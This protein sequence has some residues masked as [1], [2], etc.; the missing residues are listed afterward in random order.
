MGLHFAADRPALVLLRASDCGPVPQKS[1]HQPPSNQLRADRDVQLVELTYRGGVSMVV[2]LPDAA[3]GLNAVE[4]RLAGSYQGWMKALDHKP[5]DLELPRWKVTSRLPTTAALTAMGMQTAFTTRANFQGMSDERL[6]IQRVLQQ[7]F[8]E[9][10]EEG[11]EA[12]AVTAVV[13]GSLSDVLL[14]ASRSRFM[15][16]T[17]SCTSCATRTRV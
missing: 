10:D 16:T 4:A 6:F 1:P 13:M 5:V 12:A 15:P 11:T 14:H 2:V 17:R 8:V 3:D 9:V 7:A